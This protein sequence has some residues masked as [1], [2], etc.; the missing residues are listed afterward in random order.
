MLP[1]SDLQR[2][3]K[4]ALA[5]VSAQPDVAEVEVFASADTNL[6]CRLNY[7]SHIPSNG[8]EEPKSTDSYGLGLRVVFRSPTSGTAGSEGGAKTGF[9]SEPTDLSL[10]GVR[11][12]LDKARAGAVVDQE[13]VSLPRP[14]TPPDADNKG[15]PVPPPTMIQRSYVSATAVWWTLDGG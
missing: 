14:A 8:V 2:A 1:L 7:T 4:E 13:F 15:T 5:Y 3:T 10:E 6:T 12:S 9:G 11:R